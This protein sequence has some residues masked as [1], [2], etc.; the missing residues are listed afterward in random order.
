MGTGDT[1]DQFGEDDRLAEAGTAEQAGLPAA[2]ERGQEVD[3]LDAGLEELS[4]RGEI[5]DRRWIAVDRPALR[6]VHR[7]A[8][9]DRLA[10]EIEDAAERLLADRHGE[11]GAGVDAGAATDHAVGAAE[12]DTTH[13]AAAEM[14]LH[15]PDDVHRHPLRVMVDLHGVVDRRDRVLG[16]LCVER[17]PND[18]GDMTDLAAMLLRCRC[19]AS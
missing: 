8:V 3:D 15:F 2:D 5:G 7:A 4:L 14:L 17:R 11:W 18:L 16:E 10:G 13:L 1:G 19:H 9:V 6:R 12:G